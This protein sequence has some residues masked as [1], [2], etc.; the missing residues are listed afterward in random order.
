MSKTRGHARATN[1][2]FSSAASLPPGNPEGELF[3]LSLLAIATPTTEERERRG[4]NVC[5]ASGSLKPE[6]FPS[7]SRTFRPCSLSAYDAWLT[8]HSLLGSPA[9]AQYIYFTAWAS[10]HASRSFS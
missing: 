6:A 10:L 1:E 2:E 9:E 3:F 7:P 8:K 4:E 5:S